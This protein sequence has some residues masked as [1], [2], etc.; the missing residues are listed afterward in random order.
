MEAKNIRNVRDTQE[1]LSTLY[2]NRNRDFSYIYG[3][4]DRHQG[5]LS[6]ELTKR[7]DP[8]VQFIKCA[9]WFFA[10]ASHFEID[11][12]NAL[13]GRHP[14][15]CPYCL[16]TTCVCVVTG[17]LPFDRTPAYKIPERL[18]YLA[19]NMEDKDAQTL[20]THAKRINGIYPGNRQTYS[21]FGAWQLAAKLQ[22][23]LSEVHEAG[24]RYIAKKKPKSAVAE[25][26]AD[27]FAWLL[28]SWEII[29]PNSELQDE[30]IAYYLEGCPECSKKICEC[31]TFADRTSELVDAQQMRLIGELLVKLAKLVNV[32]DTA[33]VSQVINV[34]KSLA[35]AEETQSEP[36]ART[37]AHQAA[38]LA[39]MLEKKLDKGAK[40]AGNAAKLVQGIRTLV[41]NLPFW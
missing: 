41:E 18:D 37:A 9:S 16:A 1:F 15:I 24:T 36:I 14:G 33:S 32:E 7:S 26:L 22:E 27:A 39:E 2:P 23:E 31:D 4:A 38:N 5:F 11:V 40:N 28:A 10:L 25:E 34:Q 12:M 17:K 30:L 6:K 13:I 35:A 20:G 3:Y 19:S 21:A 29:Y 8:K